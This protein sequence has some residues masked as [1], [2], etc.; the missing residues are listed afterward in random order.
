M[1]LRGLVVLVLLLPGIVYAE[2]LDL[3]LPVGDFAFT[4][5]SG[6]TVR[7]DDLKGKVWIASFIMTYCQDGKCPAVTQ[8]MQKLQAGLGQ[9]DDVVLVTFSVDP[10]RDSLDQLRDYADS[11]GADRDRWLFLRGDP[12]EIDALLKT[13]LLPTRGSGDP[14]KPIHVQKLLLVDRDGNLVGYYEG[15]DSPSFPEGYFDKNQRG[16][17][18]HI[19]RLTQKT[20]PAWMP[21][22]FPLFNAGLNALAGVLLV[23]GFIAVKAGLIRLHKASMLT[24][25][26]VSGI[27]LTSYLFYH[28]YVKGGQPTRFSWNCYG[29]PE[30]AATVYHVVLLSHTILAIPTAPLA[31]VLAYQGLRDRIQQ[32]RRLAKWVFPVWLYVSVTG[33]VVYWMLYRLYPVA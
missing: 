2:A 30:W 24:A 10:E 26:L 13:M 20:V 6:K 7:R 16:L 31:L 18:R 29:A 23:L 19:E 14:G 1:N 3:S 25:I 9:R 15:M 32:H 17:R 21:S 5:R 11:F 4:E 8:T 22:D 28:L 33:V 12:E 27:F